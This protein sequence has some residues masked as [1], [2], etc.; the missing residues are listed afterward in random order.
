[1]TRKEIQSALIKAG[2]TRVYYA[3]RD[4]ELFE[5]YGKW[6]YL[7]HVLGAILDEK[8]DSIPTAA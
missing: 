7:F 8:I 5:E 1:M 3:E 6:C 4:E 2:V